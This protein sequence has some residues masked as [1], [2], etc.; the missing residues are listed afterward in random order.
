MNKP[1]TITLVAA[2]AA[3][4]FLSLI[5][6]IPN[7]SITGKASAGQAC[8]VPDE[9]ACS[10]ENLLVCIGNE[11]VL[12]GKI[13]GKCDYVAISRP[14]V[15]TVPIEPPGTGSSNI[16]WIFFGVLALIILGAIGF[17]I[18]ILIK[19]K[20]EERNQAMKKTTS[21]KPSAPT[22]PLHLSPY[23]YKP[24]G[25]TPIRPAAQ[26]QKLAPSNSNEVKRFSP[27]PGR[28]VK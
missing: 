11:F 10:G 2:F 21:S 14:P 9:E 28:T 18:Y 17:I 24:S 13:N 1:I 26:A 4:I 5:F 15:T 20:N 25:I 8:N 7:T 27:P 22:K 19:K 23:A 3:L 16:F 12:V 6:F